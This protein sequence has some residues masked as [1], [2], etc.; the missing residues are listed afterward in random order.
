MFRVALVLAVLYMGW[1]DTIP[2]EGGKGLAV[3]I[4]ENVN[5]EPVETEHAAMKCVPKEEKCCVYGC[6]GLDQCC[7]PLKCVEEGHKVQ[8]GTCRE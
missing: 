8:V 2:V 3:D 5:G 4:Q 6:R 1:T 7:G